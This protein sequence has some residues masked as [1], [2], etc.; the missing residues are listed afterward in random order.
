M[1]LQAEDVIVWQGDSITD[2][3]RRR[4]EK[5]ANPNWSGLGCGYALQ[6]SAV[7]LAKYPQ[8]NLKCYN[9]GISGNR[10]PD[11]YARWT[12]D[13]LNLK[14]TLVSILIGVNDTWHGFTSNQGV[15]VPKFERVY[16]QLLQETKEHNPAIKLVLCEPFVLRC[17][18]VQDPWVPEIEA[19][20]AVVAKLAKE[21]DTV[22]VKF[23]SV[24]DAALKEAPAAYW[25]Y[26]G[27]HPTMAGHQ[28]IAQAWL[29]AI[30]A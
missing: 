21:F 22:L 14:P 9:R 15:S 26:D 25:A 30:G 13:C 28:R 5:E 17:G 19:R 11:M 12:E 18:V 7:L 27:V 2:A 20:Q 10:V 1:L 29:Q 4:E 23:Q 6:A 8:F 24:F 16:R 3:T